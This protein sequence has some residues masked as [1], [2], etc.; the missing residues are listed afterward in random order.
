MR[1][2]FFSIK[3]DF[4][5][6]L[7]KFTLVHSKISHRRRNRRCGEKWICA[8][9]RVIKKT[10]FDIIFGCCSSMCIFV[11]EPV[12]LFSLFVSIPVLFL[13][14]ISL[15]EHNDKCSLVCGIFASSSWLHN[16]RRLICLSILWIGDFLLNLY[17]WRFF[18]WSNWRTTPKVTLSVLLKLSEYSM[19][20]RWLAT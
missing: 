13:S 3:T 8:S 15:R 9:L 18:N 19:R 14:R 10:F 20:N 6:L 16:Q 1:K 2:D 12:S 7:K 5:L 17:I 11:V 4:L